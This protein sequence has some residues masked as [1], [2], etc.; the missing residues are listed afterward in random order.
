M[1]H[2]LIEKLKNLHKAEPDIDA[3]LDASV[4]LLNEANVLEEA[5][6]EWYER[7]PDDDFSTDIR[8]VYDDWDF[9][10]N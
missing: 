4:N 1:E 7:L 2:S 8:R 3:F 5:F 6:S 9:Y 10:F